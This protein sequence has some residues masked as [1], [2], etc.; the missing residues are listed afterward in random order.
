MWQDVYGRT[1]MA[2]A[3]A[4]RPFESLVLLTVRSELGIQ[5]TLP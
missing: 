1:Y 5:H 3:I 4:I 2:G